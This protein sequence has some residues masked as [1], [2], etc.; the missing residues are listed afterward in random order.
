MVLSGRRGYGKASMT[1]KTL[2]HATEAADGIVQYRTIPDRVH[3]SVG[4]LLVGRGQS[5]LENRH[6]HAMAIHLHSVAHTETK[7]VQWLCSERGW[8][9]LAS[10]V[11]ERLILDRRRKHSRAT[12]IAC[13][14]LMS[15]I[16]DRLMHT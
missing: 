6:A 14:Y 12:C 16:H 7:S 4:A 5:K 2:E 1:S 9:P 11:A 13:M 8:Q 10:A 15:T 3:N